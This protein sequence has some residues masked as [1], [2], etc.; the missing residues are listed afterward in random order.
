MAK[1]LSLESDGRGEGGAYFTPPS[2]VALFSSGCTLLD[3]S[4]GGGWPE[5]RIV[6]IVGDKSTGK[7]L[8]A[9]EA[10]ANFALVYPKGKIYYRETEAA[11]DE[12]YAQR[13]GLPLDRVDMLR[14]LETV[15]DVFEDMEAVIKRSKGPGLYILD[16]LDAVSDRAE[17]KRKIDDATYGGTKPKQLGQ[18][19][20][21]LT[22]KMNTA[23]V[24]FII[25][26]QVRDNIG[27]M[28]GEKHT[29]TGGRALDFYASQIVWLAHLKQISRTVNKIKRVVG[30]QIKAK[31]KKNKIGPPF[32]EVDF[33][34]LFSYGMDDVAAACDWFEENDIGTRELAAT[35]CG[36]WKDFRKWLKTLDDEEFAVERRRLSR[37]VKREWDRVEE[38]FSPKRSK[39]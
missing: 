25:I 27:V 33:P 3:C 29:R 37:L 16:S 9:I 2:S 30:V 28:F 17:Q 1:R 39:Y 26:S 6:N 13:L 32:R 21:R 23:K 34:I 31:V 12:P 11:F 4:L 7:T 15:E 22:Q 36:N 20:R 8:L 14:G 5:G 24:T 35:D 38:T 19:F 10:S 18:L